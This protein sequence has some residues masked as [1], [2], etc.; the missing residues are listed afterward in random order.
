MQLF[1]LVNA[2]LASSS[3]GG[4]GGGGSGGVGLRIAR[5][6][7]MPL[8]ANSGLIGWVRGCDTLHQVRGKGRGKGVWAD[9]RVCLCSFTHTHAHTHTCTRNK[10]TTQT[11]ENNLSLLQLVR[12]YRESRRV[13]LHLEQRLILQMAPDY[14]RLPLLA[15]VEVRSPCIIYMCVCVCL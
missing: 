7:V 14:D 3:E 2:L 11:L 5:F 8:S 9:G 10:N 4:G 1:G 13:P 15:K 6:A 12:D